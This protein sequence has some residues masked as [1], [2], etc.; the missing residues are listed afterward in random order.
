M[1]WGRSTF[2][3]PQCWPGVSGTFLM[4]TAGVVLQDLYVILS[5]HNPLGFFNHLTC[6]ICFAFCFVIVYYIVQM[7]ITFTVKFPFSLQNPL[8]KGDL[9]FKVHER[10]LYPLASNRYFWTFALM[11]QVTL[12][13]VPVKGFWIW[14]LNLA[15]LLMKY[16]PFVSEKSCYTCKKERQRQ[17]DCM[18][19]SYFQ[20]YVVDQSLHY[21]C[22][23]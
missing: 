13:S 18:F 3:A 12:I 22:S 4:I 2:L 1:V 15:L 14:S 8:F 21:R 11:I 19:K 23:H 20:V 16:S 7:N 10:L 17:T 5:V 9:M 6:T